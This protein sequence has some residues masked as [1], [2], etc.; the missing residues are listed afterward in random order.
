MSPTHSRTKKEL[1]DKTKK[2]PKKRF[3]SSVAL[4]GI[5]TVKELIGNIELPSNPG[6][7]L[8]TDQN[9]DDS[10]DGREKSSWYAYE[11][12]LNLKVTLASTPRQSARKDR[13]LEDLS[14]Y[15]QICIIGEE[16]TT[17]E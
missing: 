3:A 13:S 12:R 14:L 7:L 6:L 17:G 11:F 5:R 1:N 8:T 9:L 4:T 16:V 2:A 15:Q 10:N